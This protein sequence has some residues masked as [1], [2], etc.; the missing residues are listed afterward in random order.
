MKHDVVSLRRAKGRPISKTC[1]LAGE[2]RRAEEL[3]REFQI[4]E[5]GMS[6]KTDADKA[7]YALFGIERKIT[8]RGI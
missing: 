1:V 5:E 3:K 8:T 6:S 7:P 4:K 2:P